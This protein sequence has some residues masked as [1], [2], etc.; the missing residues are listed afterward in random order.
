MGG[1]T[2]ESET[3]PECDKEGEMVYN[4]YA[5]GIHCQACGTWFNT[6]GD[7]LEEECKCTN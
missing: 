5:D 3:C 4:Q 7:V 2:I 6:N 1:Y